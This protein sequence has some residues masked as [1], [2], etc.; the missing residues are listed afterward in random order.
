MMAYTAAAQLTGNAR[1]EEVVDDIY[2]YIARD[3]THPSGGFY[4]AEDADSLPSHESGHKLEGAFCVWS[5]AEVEQLLGGEEMEG[6]TLA[7][8]V[9][10]EFHMAENGNVSP[11]G[12]PHG[13]L[14]GQNVLTRLPVVQP[15]CEENK[16]RE[17][18]DHSSISELLHPWARRLLASPSSAQGV[19][20]APQK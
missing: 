7:Q 13:E 9:Q 4:S 11:Q 10:H 6:H 1:F 5:W 16:Y 17:G 20:I 3:L 12:D 14:K 2:T 8:L 19:I 18:L 15:L